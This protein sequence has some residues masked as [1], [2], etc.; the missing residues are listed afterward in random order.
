MPEFI[1]DDFAKH[2]IDAAHNRV[3]RLQP[4]AAKQLGEEAS[5]M[6]T[7]GEIVFGDDGMALTGAGQNAE[8]WVNARVAEG[9]AYMEMPTVAID[10]ANDVWTKVGADGKLSLTKQGERYKIIK[11]ALVTDAAALAAIRAE[12]E[13]YSTSFGSRTPGVAPGTKKIEPDT[14][15]SNPFN[16]ARKYPDQDARNVDLIKYITRLGTPAAQKSAAKYSVDLA[17]RPL[18]TKTR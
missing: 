4:S 18:R 6:V 15:A 14:D 1:Y 12:A 10:A 9:G 3:P 13:L 2:V 8:E 16:P 11:A 5:K 7:R 17:G